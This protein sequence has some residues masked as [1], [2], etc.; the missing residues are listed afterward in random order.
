VDGTRIVT[1]LRLATKKPWAIDVA[2]FT[3]TKRP[4]HTR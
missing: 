4:L 3:P 2:Y 1:T